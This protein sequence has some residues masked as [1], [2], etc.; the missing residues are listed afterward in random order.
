MLV[1]PWNFILSPGFRFRFGVSKMI[2]WVVWFWSFIVVLYWDWW[3]DWIVA[4]W[5]GLDWE[6]KVRRRM[7]R[8]VRM[9]VMLT[10]FI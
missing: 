10:S 2:S 4:V 5:I 8:R 1:F 7:P 9:M 6:R 3:I